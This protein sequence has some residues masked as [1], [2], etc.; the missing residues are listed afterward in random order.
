VKIDKEA[1]RGKLDMQELSNVPPY[2]PTLAMSSMVRPAAESSGAFFVTVLYRFLG[3]TQALTLPAKAIISKVMKQ[4]AIAL[5]M[6]FALLALSGCGRTR[7]PVT[8]PPSAQPGKAKLSKMIASITSNLE[9]LEAR[10]AKCQVQTSDTTE[11]AKAENLL[12][13]ARVGIEELKGIR[14]NEDLP[15]KLYEVNSKFYEADKIL[16]VLEK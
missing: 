2:F 12:K 16:S 15:R 7:E 10:L 6:G 5:S 9:R 13:E 1:N 14:N 8:K 11:L 4:I 3:Y